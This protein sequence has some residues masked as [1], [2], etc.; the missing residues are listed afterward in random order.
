MDAKSLVIKVMQ[1]VAACR[2]TVH[3]ARPNLGMLVNQSRQVSPYRAAP[4]RSPCHVRTRCR[5]AVKQ[6]VSAAAAGAPSGA[7]S[8]PLT[9]NVRWYQAQLPEL[10]L[11]KRRP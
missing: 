4:A 1:I 6:W 10:A 5:P 2:G 11:L 7:Q 9:Q 8:P 3:A